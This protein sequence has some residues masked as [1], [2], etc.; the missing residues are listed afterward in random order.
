MNSK[1]VL[2]AERRL[3]LVDKIAHQRLALAQAVTPL[4][5][6]LAIADR[7]ILAVRFLAQSPFLLAGV[8]AAAVF[9]R[10]KG[11]M[12]MLQKGWLAWRLALAARHRLKE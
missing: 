3:A 10:R 6:P 5:R 12:V 8:A 4:R 7:V 2:L 9:Y 1:I 11:W